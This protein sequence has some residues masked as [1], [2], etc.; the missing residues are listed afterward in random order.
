VSWTVILPLA[1]LTWIL[2]ASVIIIMQRRSATATLAWLFALALLPIIGIIVYWLIG[3]QRLRRRRLQRGLSREVVRAAVAGLADARASAPALA[4]LSL[5]PMRLGEPPPLP[6]LDITPYFDGDAAFRDMFAAIEA[7]QHHVHLEYYIWEPDRLGTRLRDLL[8]QKAR[9]GVE[10]R[11]V[12]D[13]TGAGG[14]KRRWRK[15]LYAAGVRFAWFNPLT[16][17]FWR[18]RRADFRTHRKILVCD[19]TIG[20]TGG[21]NVSDDH[22]AE[23][24]PAYWR[25][26]H[27]SFR[28]PAV[29]TLQR[30]FFEDW[31]YASG[32]LPHVE[33][34]YFPPAPPEAIASDDGDAVQVVSS[35]PD[36]PAYAVHKAFFAAITSARHR[37][38]L[39]TPYFIPDEPI[40]MALAVAALSGVDVRVVVPRKSDSKVVDLA[41]RSYFA[42]LLTVGVKI[43]EYEPRFIHAKTFVV[44]D[45]LAIIST[46]NLDNRSFKLDFELAALVYGEHL[47]NQLAAQFIVDQ[48]ASRPVLP[49]DLERQPFLTRL[50]QSAARLLSPLL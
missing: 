15:P 1:E 11:L 24:G 3:P 13:G 44:D 14:L 30:A 26:T 18:R 12:V 9:D 36:D 19:G 33:P 41:A 7:A 21:M 22:C 20:F 4:R 29:W 6:A 8:C 49:S 10:V 32:E 37:L 5:V 50:G 35:G 27:L 25:D 2:L 39:T 16:F 28:G 47:T 17:K 34:V 42:E 48:A 46:A 38:W 31:H 43:Y 23:F 45:A 40:M